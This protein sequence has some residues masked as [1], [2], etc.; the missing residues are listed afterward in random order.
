[1]LPPLADR[2][3]PRQLSEMVGQSHLLGKQGVISHLIKSQHLP[4][5][6]LYGPPGSGKTTLAKLLAHQFHAQLY[7]LSAVSSG[8][9]QIK[10]VAEQI[11]SKP[12]LHQQPV[13]FVDEI[14]RFNKSQQDALLPYVESGL[15]TLIG[16]TT[17]NPSYE[18]N[19]ALLSRC[20][21]IVLRA[22]SRSDLAQLIERALTQDSELKQHGLKIDS[23]AKQ[24]LIQQ[25]QG[26]ARVLFNLLENAAMAAV[27]GKQPQITVE[28]LQ[29]TSPEIK[30]AYDKQAALPSPSFSAFLRSMRAGAA[31]AAL[32]YLARMIEAGEDPKFIARRMIIFAS[33]DIGLANSNALLLAA[34]AMRAVEVIGLPEAEINLAHVVCYLSQA[35]KDRSAY[36][37]YRSAQADVKRLG[38]LPIPDK[39]KNPVTQFDKNLG[40]GQGYQMYDPT[41]CLPEKLKG[42]KYLKT[43]NS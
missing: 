10:Q 21:V 31:G 12:L 29:Q 9:K 13:M 36:N 11:K 39:L 1:M 8:V 34:S 25:S 24:W 4:S 14:H 7:N 15:F 41:S 6:I 23:A 30:L 42:K 5:L 2:M 38:A 26:D 20:Q 43:D 27:A 22:L 37:A 17:Q 3:R 32:Y 40:Y 28:L 35:A 18:I 16:A 33:E 19:H